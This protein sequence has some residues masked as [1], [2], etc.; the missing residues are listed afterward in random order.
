MTPAALTHLGI[1]LLTLPAFVL[2]ALAMD[3]HQ[4]DLLGRTLSRRMSRAIRLCAALLLMAALSLGISH[5][6]MAL[7]LVSWVGHLSISAALVFVGL[8]VHD[9]W[10]TRR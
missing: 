2:L 7:G 10:C 4:E 1:Q 8:I 3:R 5:R 6:G 9:R